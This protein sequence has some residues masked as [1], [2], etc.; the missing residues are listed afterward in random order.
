MNNDI[1]IY[2]KGIYYNADSPEALEHMMKHLNSFHDFSLIDCEYQSGTRIKSSYKDRHLTH[3][4]NSG[5]SKLILRYYGESLPLPPVVEL[6]FSGVIEYSINDGA[7]LKNIHTAEVRMA[8]HPYKGNPIPLSRKEIHKEDDEDDGIVVSETEFT[9]CHNNTND[10]VIHFTSVGSCTRVRCEPFCDYVFAGSLRW[11]MISPELYYN[12]AVPIEHSKKDE[13]DIIKRWA[14]TFAAS[15]DTVNRLLDDAEKKDADN[16]LWCLI[17][18][19]DWLSGD[20]ARKAFDE[21][22]YSDAI[23][24]KTAYYTKDPERTCLEELSVIG[25]AGHEEFENLIGVPDHYIVDRDFKWTYIH[26][27]EPE[28][29]PFF[30]FK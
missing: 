20:E 7:I 28:F 21:L 5:K 4:Y 27:H 2:N 22:E 17:D 13:Y 30:R 29:G 6:E 24:F 14:N 11:R 8:D 26:T 23:I 16:L 15:E 12:G 3:E 18:M 19:H 25:K 9:S 1:I 10:K